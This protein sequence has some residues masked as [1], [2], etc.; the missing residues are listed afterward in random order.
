MK[1]SRIPTA[2]DPS[3]KDTHT[4]QYTAISPKSQ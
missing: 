2:N 4:M 3:K 1:I